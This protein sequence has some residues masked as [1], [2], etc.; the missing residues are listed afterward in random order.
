LVC[1]HQSWVFAQLVLVLACVLAEAM[2]P[3]GE[4]LTGHDLCGMFSSEH[5]AF[6]PLLAVN[7]VLPSFTLGARPQ[8][9]NVKD[10][11]TRL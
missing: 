1:R 6:A 2:T 9:E 4:V 5:P 8:P 10:G 7:R 11:A 3:V